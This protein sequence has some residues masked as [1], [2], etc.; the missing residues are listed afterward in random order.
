[1]EFHSN[2][3]DKI[4]TVDT[5]SK[6]KFFIK[7]GISITS[8]FLTYLYLL[9]RSE[10]FK[11]EDLDEFIIFILQKLFFKIRFYDSNCK[12]TKSRTESVFSGL[13]VFMKLPAG[14]QCKTVTA[15]KMI[16]KIASEKPFEAIIPDKITIA[17][18]LSLSTQLEL[19]DHNNDQSWFN[20][21]VELGN[22]DNN[23]F[24]FDAEY[25]MDFRTPGLTRTQYPKTI[26]LSFD[27]IVKNLK[28]FVEMNIK[29]IN[30]QDLTKL[31]KL[32]SNIPNEAEWEYDLG[33]WRD[34]VLA[35]K[36]HDKVSAIKAL[37]FIEKPSPTHFK[38]L[39]DT[40]MITAEAKRTNDVRKLHEIASRDNIR[41]NK[42]I[43]A[44]WRD[45]LA[46]ED[47]IY[48]FELIKERIIS[49]RT[50]IVQK[51]VPEFIHI[52]CFEDHSCNWSAAEEI[53]NIK[54]ETELMK[55]QQLE[56][57]KLEFKIGQLKKATPPIADNAPEVNL[58]TYQNIA[59][60]YY[61]DGSSKDVEM[62]RSEWL[63][64]KTNKNYA[65]K[66]LDGQII[67][68]GLTGND[69]L[70]GLTEELLNTRFNEIAIDLQTTLDEQK[71]KLLQKQAKIEKMKLDISK[72]VYGLQVDLTNFGREV[73]KYS[74]LVKVLWCNKKF[75]QTHEKFCK[76]IKIAPVAE[77][78]LVALLSSG[79]KDGFSVNKQ[80]AYIGGSLS[81]LGSKRYQHQLICNYLCLC[82]GEKLH[83]KLAAWQ[84]EFFRELGFIDLEEY[85]GWKMSRRYTYTE[86]F[87][88]EQIWVV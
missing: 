62:R 53:G 1:M 11:E 32:Q 87:N 17:D 70:S 18:Y 49:N 57:E 13:Y 58:D 74:S 9:I 19:R 8:I 80:S 30:D 84:M 12:M 64:Q 24:K 65:K 38:S 79:A 15:Y 6:S 61:S 50:S 51:F 73:K 59:R 25:L 48:Q 82:F 20:E 29:D 88:E 27:S 31:V 72:K 28:R 68:Y 34:H 75:K 54:V 23:L 14:L 26:A 22:I 41:F 69:Y 52:D 63:K 86:L 43:L 66:V 4:L 44:L 35:L 56:I 5:E 77:N 47:V 81:S 37:Q 46:M 60:Y 67:G 39:Q 71:A 76:K 83:Y 2:L 10:L 85:R 55:N 3:K 16:A 42:D 7:F 40:L 21:K 45:K 33:D 78:F 36:F